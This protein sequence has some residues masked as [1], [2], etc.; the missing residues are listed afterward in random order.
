MVR[1]QTTCVGC[2]KPFST[3]QPAVF[4]CEFR[5][6]GFPLNIDGTGS[7]AV[8]CGVRYH[9]E[10]I[11]AGP[12]F[13]TRLGANKGL[14]C[15]NLNLPHFICELCQVRAM[16]GRELHNKEADHELLLLER[17]RLLDSVN[18]WQQ[19]TMTT[20][21]PYLQFMH[22]FGRRYSVAVLQPTRLTRPPTSEGIALVWAQ[23]LYSLRVYKGN[24]IKFNTIR[25]IRSVASSFYTWDLHYTFPGRVRRDGGRDEVCDFVLPSEEAG[26]TFATKGLA[27]RIGTQ[28]KPSWALS[29][30]HIA[31]LD[32]RLRE[33][34]SKSTDDAYRH[35]LACAGFANILGYLGWLRGTELFE[36]R[37]EDLT[38]IPPNAGAT[39]GL[40]PNIGAILLDLMAETKTNPCQVADLVLAYETLSG[41]SPGYWVSELRR[42][43]S[44]RHGRI[45]ST[46]TEPAWSS[47]YFRMNYAWPLLEEMMEAGEPTLQ[48]FMTEEGSTLRKHIYSMHS[49]RRAGRS[50]AGRNARHNEPRPK[51][52]RK[53][54]DDE[55]YEHGRWTKRRDRKGEAIAALYNQWG[56]I[57]RLAITIF[58]M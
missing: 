31:Y 28:T 36:A 45:F 55:I 39:Y 17:M 7:W 19:S 3:K 33:A 25:M 20:Y 15:P 40:P 46:K 38:I 49:W 18:Y 30:I 53:A 43:S 11:R 16:L 50:R 51:G 56:L 14:L 2:A 10:C 9:G 41:L 35:E 5:H 57:E 12:P 58:C 29:H 21:G 27:R 48:V 22:R 4:H 26:V 34:Y 44:C 8:P 1:R 52:T 23:L 6:Q 42:F 37:Y 47:R 24:P 32:Q 54:T 13:R